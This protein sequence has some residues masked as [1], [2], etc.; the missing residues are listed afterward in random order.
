MPNDTWSPSNPPNPNKFFINFNQIF[1][2]FEQCIYNKKTVYI[3]GRLA[4]LSLRSRRH[5][6]TRILLVRAIAAVQ[7][8]HFLF[9]YGRL[10]NGTC[11]IVGLGLDPFV[12]TWPAEQMAAHAYDG[13]P[14][15]IQTNVALVLRVGARLIAARVLPLVGRVGLLTQHHL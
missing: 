11:L 8:D 7:W 10:A 12:Q 6:V 1:V 9:A 13:V 14:R 15:R 3:S 2:Y 4:A 5:L